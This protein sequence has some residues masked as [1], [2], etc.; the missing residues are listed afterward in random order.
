MES[1]LL[2]AVNYIKNISMKKVTFTKIEAFMRK[3]EL[4]TCK[5][6][7]DNIIDS[8]IENGLI[9]VR[10]D[11]ENAIFQIANEVNSSQ[12]SPSPENIN[13]GTENTEENHTQQNKEKDCATMETL[14]Y[15]SSAI[16]EKIDWSRKAVVESKFTKL[17]L[18]NTTPVQP[19]KLNTFNEVDMTPRQPKG[20]D[21]TNKRVTT[22]SQRQ[23]C[24]LMGV[25]N[26]SD[27]SVFDLFKN[28][29]SQL[30]KEISK[31][32]EIIS[33][34]TQQLS[35]KNAFTIPLQNQS[36]ERRSANNNPLNDSVESEI[37]REEA[38]T[39]KLNKKRKVVVTGASLLN[40]ISE[41]GLSRDHQVTVKNFPGGTSEKISEEIENLLADK[42]GCITIHAGTSD[43]ANGINSLNLVK[44]I[45]KN[46]KKSSPSRKLVFSNIFSGKIKKTFRKKWQISIVA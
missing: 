21:T 30:E 3:K 9:Q 41:K 22:S 32:D 26:K 13:D 38:H 43:I 2:N 16:N 37:P 42:P 33:F 17:D 31:K 40:G 20:V 8:F 29:I 11:V 15:D 12:I 27:C 7:L 44:K 45:A 25:G 4:F 28:R 46:V 34:L 36:Q 39:V 6:D 10:G 18:K 1:E 14:K 24:D 23:Q 5:E 35:V 19:V